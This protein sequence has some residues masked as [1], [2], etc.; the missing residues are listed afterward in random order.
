MSTFGQTSTM[1]LSVL[2]H[3]MAVSSVAKHVIPNICLCEQTWAPSLQPKT[4]EIGHKAATF[5]SFSYLF[6]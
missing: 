3:K 5:A 1:K 6:S 4:D 2:F